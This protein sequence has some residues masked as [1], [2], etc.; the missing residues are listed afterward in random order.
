MI[1]G[2]KGHP[3]SAQGPYAIG[4]QTPGLVRSHPP[5]PQS[6]SRPIWDLQVFE[7]GPSCVGVCKLFFF[8]E[9]ETNEEN[10]KAR[11]RREKADW[12]GRD[13]KE[14][15]ELSQGQMKLLLDGKSKVRLYLFVRKSPEY[16]L[17]VVDF[18]FR[19]TFTRHF[20]KRKQIKI[21]V[22]F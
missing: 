17:E 21:P 2:Y 5:I 12:K 11:L 3:N 15:R 13:M 19:F 1:G 22:E 14:H 10:L 16:L 20:L 18:G 9:L 8:S 4:D 7:L 6:L